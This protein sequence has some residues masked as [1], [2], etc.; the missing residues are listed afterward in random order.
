MSL[1]EYIS[2][3]TSLILSFS[4]ARSL[5]N[6]API[7]AAERRDWVHAS[8][9]VGLLA[10]HVTLFWQL[11]AYGEAPSW[12][13]I[14]FVLLLTGP[15]SVLIAVSLLVPLDHAADYRAHF[16]SVRVPFYAVL[17][18]MQIQPVPLFYL[19]FDL[20][21]AFHPMFVSNVVFALAG[22]VG[23]VARRRV[24]DGTLVCFFL[25]GLFGALLTLN[26]HDA[27][28]ATVRQLTS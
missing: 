1:F 7:F 20:P 24:V 9:V 21:L 19:A 13:L 22:L 17:V 16:E 4:L 15:I 3:A 11:W 6:V 27:L 14:E 26:T 12:T 10:Y 5:T 28:L 25:L 18:T 2:I 8:W 23:L